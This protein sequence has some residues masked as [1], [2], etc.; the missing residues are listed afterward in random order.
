VVLLDRRRKNKDNLIGF[1]MGR[2]HFIYLC[3][4]GSA[5][6]FMGTGAF[7]VLGSIIL[8]TFSLATGIVC[9]FMFGLLLDNN[10]K[11]NNIFPDKL[12]GRL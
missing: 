12:R 6:G 1:E 5:L 3:M 9:L 2:D 4:F 7:L 10:I 11:K 8:F